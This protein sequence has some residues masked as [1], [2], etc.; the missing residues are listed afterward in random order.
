[1]DG[2][3]SLQ[4]ADVSAT[5]FAFG[6]EMAVVRQEEGESRLVVRPS[7]KL[8]VGFDEYQDG[9]LGVELEV[10]LIHPDKM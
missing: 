4:V 9:V 10:Q 8:G 1:M 6:R 3:L 7:A 2:F 5:L